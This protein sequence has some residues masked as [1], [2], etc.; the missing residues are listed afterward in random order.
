MA[1][2]CGW[3]VDW[4]LFHRD[5][6]SCS[7]SLWC[8][9]AA[10]SNVR[11]VVEEENDASQGSLISL[12]SNPKL[13]VLNEQFLFLLCTPLL[14]KGEWEAAPRGGGIS[15]CSDAVSGMLDFGTSTI[16]CG[17][18]DGMKYDSRKA[19]LF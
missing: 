10:S 1:R 18:T 3:F 11:C 7:L 6:G 9:R 15:R 19:L 4:C 8:H 14:C 13:C 12:D 2:L 5:G 17:L 16:C